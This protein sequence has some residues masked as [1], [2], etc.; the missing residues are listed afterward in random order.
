MS[1]GKRQEKRMPVALWENGCTTCHTYGAIGEGK[2]Q[3]LGF[4]RYVKASIYRYEGNA[5]ELKNSKRH[6]P[7][8]IFLS[9]LEASLC[10]SAVWPYQ[11]KGCTEMKLG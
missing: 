10:E 5:Y 3:Q 2:V 9:R 7:N 1:C 6:L 11:I 4:G 8:C